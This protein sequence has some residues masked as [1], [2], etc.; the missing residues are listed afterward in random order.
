M[1]SCV[2]SLTD[3]GFLRV[4]K[5]STGRGRPRNMVTATPLG[6][7]FLRRISEL[8]RLRLRLRDADIRKT[9][10]QAKRTQELAELGRSPYE[11]FWEL[12]ELAWNLRRAK[13]DS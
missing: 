10:R 4:G 7:C 11:T 13:E 6:M 1:Q 9:L 12:T 3:Q 2:Q 5:D 8:D